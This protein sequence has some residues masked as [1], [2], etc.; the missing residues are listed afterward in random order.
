MYMFKL[1]QM[2]DTSIS[3]DARGMVVMTTAFSKLS[4]KQHL[5]LYRRGTPINKNYHCHLNTP[6]YFSPKRMGDQ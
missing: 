1:S 3:Y 2:L 5:I 6:I 4:L